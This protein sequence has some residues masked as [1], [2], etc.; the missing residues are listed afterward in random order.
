M[1]SSMPIVIQSMGLEGF[2]AWLD[3]Q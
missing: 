1:H 2:L 3:Q